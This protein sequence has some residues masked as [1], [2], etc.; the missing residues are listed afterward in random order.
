MADIAN[1][2]SAALELPSAYAQLIGASPLSALDGIGRIMAA[3]GEEPRLRN[4][5]L[6]R[7]AT[8]LRTILEA[9]PYEADE[10]APVEI[11]LQDAALLLDLLLRRLG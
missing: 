10:A 8:R 9:H 6:L 11:D 2:R 7:T 4:A 3:M 5:L 1:E